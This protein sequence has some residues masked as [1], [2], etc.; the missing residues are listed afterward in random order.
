M[1]GTLR[2]APRPGAVLCTLLPLLAAA[3]TTSSTAPEPDGGVVRIEVDPAFSR[4]GT[5]AVS[6]HEVELPAGGSIRLVALD[7]AGR[8]VNAKWSS[9]EPSVA[10]VAGDGTVLALAPGT[11]GITASARGT[12]A[13]ATVRVSAPPAEPD[14]GCEAIPH[15]RLVPV[16]TSG[17]LEAALGDARPGDQIRLEDGVYTGFFKARVSGTADARIS[18][19]GG[20]GAVLTTGARDAGHGLWLDGASYWT[21]HGMTIRD[22]LGGLSITR[23]SHNVVER[24]EVRDV[25]Q[26]A[27]RVGI[28]S[29]S[30]VIRGN[31]IHRTGRHDPRFGEGIY[32]GSWNGSWCARTDRQPDRSDGNRIE[33]NEIGPDVTSEHVQVME[34]TTGGLIRGN[35]F[36]GRGMGAPDRPYSDSWVAVMGNGWIVEDNRGTHTLRNG[37]EVWVEVDGWGLD[38]VFRRNVA[39]LHADGWGFHL[40]A[41]AAGSVVRCDNAVRYAGSGASNVGCSDA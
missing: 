13:S 31:R 20:R 2:R 12:S 34:G 41:K 14:G 38:N 15:L 16:S 37:F 28:F 5:I 10:S 26:H 39:D 18:L 29:S 8:P 32:V 36:D 24:V 11:S 9:G 6:P 1:C 19:C 7:A 4:G 23:G 27:V 21:V 3:C 33:G 40:N 25:G 17:A 35:V 22:A 30:N